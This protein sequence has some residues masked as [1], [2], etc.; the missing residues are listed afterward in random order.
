MKSKK[1]KTKNIREKKNVHVYKLLLLVRVEVS[2]TCK[3]QKSSIISS[4]NC[5]HL[6]NHWHTLGPPECFHLI[7]PF[8]HQVP[9]H[10]S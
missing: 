1:W 6:P 3:S 4:S 5:E 8:V 9:C 2:E 10:S 7:E